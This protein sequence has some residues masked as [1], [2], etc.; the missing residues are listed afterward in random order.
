MIP[1]S[2]MKNGLAQLARE[3]RPSRGGVRGSAPTR[4][5]TGAVGDTVV[6][7]LASAAAGPLG[8]LGG[9]VGAAW[10]AVLGAVVSVGFCAVLGVGFGAGRSGFDVRGRRPK[11]TCA[12][13]GGDDGPAITLAAARGVSDHSKLVSPRITKSACFGS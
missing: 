2:S 12:L 1:R 8:V 13:E 6:D 7:V 11:A 5:A 3:P 9:G 4:P 10:G